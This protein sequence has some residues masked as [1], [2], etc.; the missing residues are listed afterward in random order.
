M[1]DI[2][3]KYVDKGILPQLQKG[4][5]FIIRN[6]PHINSLRDYFFKKIF[7]LLK[8]NKFNNLRLYDLFR[9]F[10]SD[11]QNYQRYEN[12]FQNVEFMKYWAIAARSLYTNGIISSNF[13]SLYKEIGCNNFDFTDG[14]VTRLVFPEQSKLLLRQKGNLETSYFKR[15][16]SGG[17]I[18]VFM[19]TL[20]NIH[21]DHNRYHNGFQFNIWFGMHNLKENECLQV[22]EKLYHSLSHKDQENS[23]SN[24]KKLKDS[25]NYKLSFGDCIIFHG[26]HLHTSPLNQRQ[27]NYFRHSIDIRL[28]TDTYDDNSHYRKNCKQIA[29]FSNIEESFYSISKNYY[30]NFLPQTNKY[31]PKLWSLFMKKNAYFMLDFFKK[32]KQLQCEQMM[33]EIMK[34]LYKEIWF[35]KK[36]SFKFVKE[37]SLYFASLLESKM[38]NIKICADILTLIKPYLNKEHYQ[39]LIAT[40]EKKVKTQRCLNFNPIKYDYNSRIQ[41]NPSEILQE[42]MSNINDTK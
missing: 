12:L 42:F 24:L 30:N 25:I 8:E 7:I 3:Y 34:E 29:I 40:Y 13:F 21:R 26:E 33:L 38:Q 4:K 2:H 19:P 22:F 31:I 23:L 41:K 35:F 17:E 11:T 39:H 15:N 32:N 20:A 6:V 16:E 18:E 9:N 28:I 37:T 14:G 27:K 36:Y 10:Y 5:I 1:E